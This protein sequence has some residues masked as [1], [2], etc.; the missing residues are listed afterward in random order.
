[1][2]YKFDKDKPQINLVPLKQVEKIAEVL[3]FGAKKYQ[4]ESWKTVHNAEDR[5]FSAAMRHLIAYQNNESVDKESGLSHLAHAATNLIFLLHFEDS[6]EPR[7][8]IKFSSLDDMDKAGIKFKQ[9]L[10]HAYGENSDLLDAGSRYA[11]QPMSEYALAN[12]R[13]V[14]TV[15]ANNTMSA[16][17][18]WVNA[19]YYMKLTAPLPE[20]YYY[21]DDHFFKYCEELDD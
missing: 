10:G 8:P 2:D 6:K 3:T 7:E 4:P 18:H 20:E 15:Y 11:Y 5:Y 19:L 1:M 9:Y 17:V 12:P 14:Y 13:T 21:G 16:G